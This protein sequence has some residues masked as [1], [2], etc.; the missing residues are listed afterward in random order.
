MSTRHHRGV[1]LLTDARLLRWFFIGLH[2]ETVFGLAFLHW[3]FVRSVYEIGA[4]RPY[5]MVVWATTIPIF[6]CTTLHVLT[7]GHPPVLRV[8]Q[9]AAQ[10]LALSQHSAPIWFLA[11]IGQAFWSFRV[12]LLP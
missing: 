10:A 6:W 3:L 11:L 5:C 1:V 7:V 8:P 12:D 2:L 4:L 9:R